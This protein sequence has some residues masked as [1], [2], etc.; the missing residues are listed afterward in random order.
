[1]AKIFQGFS[2]GTG[3]GRQ[4]FRAK[5]QQDHPEDQQDFTRPHGTPEESQWNHHT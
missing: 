3:H 5:Q 4:S 1:V 2:Q